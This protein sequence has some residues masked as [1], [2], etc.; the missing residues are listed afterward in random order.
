MRLR[1]TDSC[2]LPNETARV[3]R[4]F[5]K[6]APTYDRS[7]ERFER[8][9][10]AG[11]REKLCARARG[12]VLEIAAGTARNLPHYPADVSITAIELSPEMAALG[13]Q[14]AN[15]LGRDLDLRVGDAERLEFADRSFDT[16]VCTYGLCTIPD[17]AAAV[18]EAKRVLRPGGLLLLA[19]HVRS[20]NLLVR[21]IQ[22]IV[23]PIAQ[24]LGGD[25]MLRE[26]LD[27]LR[28]EG[29]EIDEVERRKA[30]F[31]ELVVARTPAAA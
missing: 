28:A 11:T 31:V 18:R 26:P 10:F 5:D 15:A 30:G 20:P 2:P 14:R 6:Q 19:E 12:K 17:D 4:I 8:T 7:M 16:V 3:Q 29:F 9:L 25:N 22:R 1:R 21:T 23:D 13:R 24:R 27:H